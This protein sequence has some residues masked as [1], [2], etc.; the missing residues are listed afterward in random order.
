M[1]WFWTLFGQQLSGYISIGDVSV[2][3]GAGWRYVH[4]L[5]YANIF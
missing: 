1:Y 2:S 3:F 4:C 5:E